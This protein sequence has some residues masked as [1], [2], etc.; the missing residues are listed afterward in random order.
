MVVVSALVRFLL[1]LLTALAVA[2]VVAAIWAVAHGGRFVH[3]FGIACFVIGGLALVFGAFGV[4]GMSP[5]LGLVETA[6]RSRDPLPGM[7][8]FFR[9]P[10]GTT[11]VN[12]T[13]IFFLTG[14]AMLVVG[15]AIHG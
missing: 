2:A 10:P 8:A 14:I 1:Q 11:A 9:T 5:S 12:A 7:P 15:F 13:A 3:T 4:G 6:G